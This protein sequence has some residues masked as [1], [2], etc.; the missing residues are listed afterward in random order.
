VSVVFMS[1][2]LSDQGARGKIKAVDK[3]VLRNKSA[4]GE[5]SIA[6]DVWSRTAGGVWFAVKTDT[7]IYGV[8]ELLA[9]V[10]PYKNPEALTA[11]ERAG[12]HSHGPRAVAEAGHGALD[13]LGVTDDPMTSPDCI[14]WRSPSSP[15]TADESHRTRAAGRS[16]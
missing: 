16:C 5:Q 10:L 9:R 12:T 4:R 6:E 2:R 11:A 1:I 3:P 13:G 14:S 15:A 8:I 7:A